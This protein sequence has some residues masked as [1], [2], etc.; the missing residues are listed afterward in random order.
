MTGNKVQCRSY[1]ELFVDVFS[2]LLK[3]MISTR[4]QV[5]AQIFVR[6]IDVPKGIHVKIVLMCSPATSNV[7]WILV[8][9]T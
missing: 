1:L 5:R 4:R 7:G 3:E 8:F 9:Q 2:F 6:T